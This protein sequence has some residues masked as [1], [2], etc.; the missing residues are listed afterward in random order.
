MLQSITRTQIL[1]FYDKFIVRG[2]VT[3]LNATKAAGSGKLSIQVFGSNHP[4]PSFNKEEEG[5]L[6]ITD[7]VLFK[8]KMY[9]YPTK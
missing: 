5:V 2:N 8:E 1:E 7:T 4:L 6:Y 9:V 3:T